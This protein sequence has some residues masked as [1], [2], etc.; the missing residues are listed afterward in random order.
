M[1]SLESQ[2]ETELFWGNLFC[3]IITNH[4]MAGPMENS[5]F[6][7]PGISMFFSLKFLG[8]SIHCSPWDQ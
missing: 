6:C 3:Y 1:L 8:N 4:L 5:E 7:F 2:Q